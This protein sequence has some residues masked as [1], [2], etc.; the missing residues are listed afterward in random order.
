MKEYSCMEDVRR[1][2]D[3]N[4]QFI[5]ELEKSLDAC[6]GD[7]EKLELLQLIGCGCSEYITGAYSSNILEREI[8][9]IGQI[10]EF[11]P[12]EKPQNGKILHVM[13]RAGKAGGH[14]TIVYNWIKN[15]KKRQYSIVFTDMEYWDIP[16]FILQSVEK[17][18]GTI[19][20]LH[21][22]FLEKAK[23]L[24]QFS[25]KFER[26]VLHIHM[27]DIVPLLAYSNKNWQI[28]VYFYNHADFR[29]SYGFSVAD[30]VLNLN[31][32]DW[33]KSKKY[34]GI[35]DEKNLILQSPNG[36]II[37]SVIC[38]EETK[39][40]VLLNFKI[41]KKR[42]LIV[43]MGDEFKYQDIIHCSFT[44]FVEKLF[45]RSKQKPQF[46]IIGPDPKKEKWKRLEE[47]TNGDARAVGYRSRQEVYSLIKAADLFIAS[48]PMRAS[49][50]GLAEKWGVP[51]LSLFVT[52]REK[53]L[54]GNNKADSIEEL[55]DKSLDILNGNT[56]KY[57]DG[58]LKHQLT[59]EEWCKKWDEIVEKNTTHNLNLFEA[60]RYIEKTDYVNCQLMQ[61]MASQNMEQYADFHNISGKFRKQLYLLDQK[62]DMDIFKKDIYESYNEKMALSDKHLK[63]YLT[64]IRWISVKQKGKKIGKYLRKKGYHTIAIYGMSY[65]GQRLVKELDDGFVEVCYGIDRDVKKK[66]S[67][68]KIY[69]PT[70]ERKPVDIIVNTTNFENSKIL[71]G[72]KDQQA[73]ML[74]LDAILEEMD[75]CFY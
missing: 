33:E 9:K 5:K 11:S 70:D 2:I 17:T 58:C 20:C 45:E 52:D 34:R 3:L 55:V 25:Q 35:A 63:L 54:F 53:D 14:S 57:K 72:M 21:G 65:M 18:G 74:S 28:P 50:A 59:P 36:G 42:K 8:V 47:R 32:F 12:E 31:K 1:R 49:G 60:K 73:K 37:D 19:L 16:K 64:A 23:Q 62:Y 66:H 7:E 46:I 48:F 43:S 41:D 68:I 29:F 27:Y 15:D 71:E 24:L 22:N 4:Y 67:E 6:E 38:D 75:K 39:E 69:H 26:I 30:V 40:K 44:Y 10:I 61:K 51:N 13:T 56:K